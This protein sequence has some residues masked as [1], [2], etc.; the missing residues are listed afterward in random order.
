[1][2]NEHAQKHFQLIFNYRGKKISALQ[3]QLAIIL[4]AVFASQHP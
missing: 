4:I 2:I 3:C 1:M